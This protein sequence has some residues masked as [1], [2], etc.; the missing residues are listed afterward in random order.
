MPHADWSAIGSWASFAATIL[1]GAFVYGRL[2]EKV[3]NV[4]ND[5]RDLKAES[6]DH[7]KR[8]TRIEAHLGIDKQSE[9]AMKVSH[10]ETSDTGIRCPGVRDAVLSSQQRVA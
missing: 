7:S 3:A 1:I 5:V 10:L 4:V 6:A 8:I 9:I 2:T